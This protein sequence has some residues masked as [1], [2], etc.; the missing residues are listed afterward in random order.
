MAT[1]RIRSIGLPPGAEQVVVEDQIVAPVVLDTATTR[2]SYVSATK[3]SLA[4]LALPKGDLSSS[5]GDVVAPSR[6]RTVPAVVIST[7]PL[8]P[9]SVI[10]RSV[11]VVTSSDRFRGLLSAVPLAGVTYERVP[12]EVTLS[13]RLPPQSATHI[14]PALSAAP[15]AGYIGATPPALKMSR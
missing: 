10:H 4:L 9:V 1:S 6:I 5:D 13:M 3:R 2:W 15:P 11:G 7:M 12:P 14:V 8:L